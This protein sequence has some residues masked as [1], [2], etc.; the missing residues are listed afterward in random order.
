MISDAC[1]VAVSQ[2]AS[3]SCAAT[4][5]FAN[6]N[7]KTVKLNGNTKMTMRFYESHFAP[8]ADI[9]FFPA[10][11][12]IIISTMQVRVNESKRR[13]TQNK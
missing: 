3:G 7:L 6:A 5:V 13:P 8:D 10:V 1:F 9:S 2:A 11:A 4:T 12:S